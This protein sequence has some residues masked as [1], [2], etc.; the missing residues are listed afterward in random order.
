MIFKM[1]LLMGTFCTLSL[2]EEDGDASTAAPA[3]TPK[4]TDGKLTIKFWFSDVRPLI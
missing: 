4:D 3:T 1:N 2:G